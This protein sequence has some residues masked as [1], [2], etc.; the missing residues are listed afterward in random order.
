MV[1]FSRAGTAIKKQVQKA[2]SEFNKDPGFYLQSA[3]YFIFLFSLVYDLFDF[4][5]YYVSQIFP[6]R[7]LFALSMTLY[8]NMVHEDI[9]HLTVDIRKSI[10]LGMGLCLCSAR[11]YQE[12]LIL[13]ILYFAFLYLVFLTSLSFISPSEESERK[14]NEPR[15]GF[16][17]CF[18]IA[19]FMF[20]WISCDIPHP[21]IKPDIIFYISFYIFANTNLVFKFGAAAIVGILFSC[22]FLR[23]QYYLKRGKVIREGIGFG[24]ILFL[25][26]FAAFF[27]T[28]DFGI[29]FFFANVIAIIF[30]FK[31]KKRQEEI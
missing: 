24:D 20:A 8:I 26:A 13:Y 9:T 1:R 22:L 10:L 30:Y 3:G 5:K 21:D 17:P 16:L 25:P 7:S 4:Q 11:P 23:K 18:A 6:G 2:T 15:L 28:I 14:T 27:G 12:F 29:T 19:L 31:V